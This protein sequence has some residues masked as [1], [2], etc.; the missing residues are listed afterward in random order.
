M[1]VKK[2]LP[3]PKNHIHISDMIVLSNPCGAEFMWRKTKTYFY[4]LSFPPTKMAQLIED[5]AWQRKVLKYSARLTKLDI[6]H[7]TL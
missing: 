7:V 6:N 1:F 3:Y 4:Y 5:L 2:N